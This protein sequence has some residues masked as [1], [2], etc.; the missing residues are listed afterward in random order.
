MV[1]NARESYQEGIYYNLRKVLE[2]EAKAKAHRRRAK[3]LQ[4]ELKNEQS[5]FYFHNDATN[6]G[7]FYLKTSPKQKHKLRFRL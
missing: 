4:R 2:H 1:E 7:K 5:A 3:Q 6:T